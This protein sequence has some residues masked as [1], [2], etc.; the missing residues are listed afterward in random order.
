MLG[1]SLPAERVEAVRF[2][3]ARHLRR[4]RK[5]ANELPEG[6]GE[7]WDDDFAVIVDFTEGGA[8]IGIRRDEE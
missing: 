8:P 4:S 6:W 3:M 7:Y 2:S 1:V 5:P